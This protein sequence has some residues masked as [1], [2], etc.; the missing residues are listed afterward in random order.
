[1]TATTTDTLDSLDPG[2]PADVY[3]L[4]TVLREQAEALYAQGSRTPSLVRV[5][6]GDVSVQVEWS[7]AVPPSAAAV[8]SAV[9]AGWADQAS[10]QPAGTPAPAP[11]PALAAAPQSTAGRHPVCA[12]T[13]GVFY[14]AMEPGAKPF[15]AEGDVIVAGQQVGIVEAMKLMTPV[16]ADRAGRV[17]EI[18]VT[19]G[20]SVEYGQPLIMVEPQS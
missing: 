17:V 5:C 2:S 3:R 16:E 10:A 7:D 14:R 18:L 13:V 12:Q 9:P 4:V 1:V 11:A 15:V 6:A 19:D 20:T 8:L